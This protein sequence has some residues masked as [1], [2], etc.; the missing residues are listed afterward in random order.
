MTSNSWFG[1]QSIQLGGGVQS[2][3]VPNCPCPPPKE[4]APPSF[5]RSNAVFWAEKKLGWALC[6]GPTALCDCWQEKGSSWLDSPSCQGSASGTVQI[7]Q[8]KRNG[9]NISIL[10]EE[11][12]EIP[13]QKNSSAKPHAA[14]RGICRKPNS[15]RKANIA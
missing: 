11:F 1:Y 10:K 6:R 8:G 7:I 12:C 14:F 4:P 5:W 13:F 2:A 9:G 3:Y 15:P